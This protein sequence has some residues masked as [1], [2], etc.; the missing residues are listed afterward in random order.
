VDKQLSAT[1]M[2][3]VYLHLVIISA[4]HKGK[5]AVDDGIFG[6]VIWALERAGRQERVVCGIEGNRSELFPIPYE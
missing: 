6:P 3:M 2:T 1:P 5:A 4:N